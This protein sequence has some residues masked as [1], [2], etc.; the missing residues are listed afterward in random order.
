MDGERSAPVPSIP[1]TERGRRT[2]AA[3]VGAARAVFED[4][5]YTSARIADIV[6]TA[7]VSYGSFYHYFESKESVLLEV[8]TVVAGEMFLA[9]RV[10]EDAP[11]DAVGRI[12]AGNRR[13]F[14]VIS[15][16]ARL[17]S[18]IEEMAFRDA[19]MLRLKLTIREPFVQRNEAGIRRLQERGAADPTV[20]ARMAAIA[21]G[22]MVEHLAQLRFIHGVDVDDEQAIATLTDVWAR[23]IGLRPEVERGSRG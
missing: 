9:S 13:Y 6:K 17:M 19:T 12:E 5:G 22:G 20:D 14:A 7:R 1:T 3:L 4:M 10:P 23:G 15:R 21:L 2:R 16:N 18:V 11:D 8:L